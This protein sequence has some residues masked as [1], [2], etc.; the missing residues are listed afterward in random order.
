M[1][2]RHL[3]N[4]GLR[5]SQA[6]LGT[7]TFGTSW[8]FGTDADQSRRILDRFLDAGGN[9]IDT[10][11]KY[12]DGESET[13]LGEALGARRDDVVLATKYSLATSATDANALGNHRRNLVRSLEHSLRRLRTD[14]VDLIWVHAWY[15]ETAVED[16]VRAL[17]DMISA[18]KVLYWG[19]SDTP[20]WAC[21]EA[22]VI[23]QLRGW[24]PLTAVQ[25][26]YNLLE[27]TG[28]RELLPF[29]RQNGVAVTGSI[30]LAGGVLTG[31]HHTKSSNVD[32]AR[33]ERAKGR[34]NEQA[35]EIVGLL[36]E[37]A[38]SMDVTAAQLAIA[39]RL[40]SCPEAIPILGR[41]PRSSSVR[42]SMPSLSTSLHRCSTS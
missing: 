15:F 34:R 40:A 1:I 9:F 27:R 35:D 21:A 33:G 32:T 12:T 13:I 11:D 10:A 18:G 37:L 39:W 28:E 20:A 29:A 4:S 3:G 38:Q 17:D 8:G 7:M 26:E 42:T 30:P 6:A 25:L 36:C 19:L 5:V 24:A 22:R 23:A 2:L 41:V 16:V 14:Y 31:K